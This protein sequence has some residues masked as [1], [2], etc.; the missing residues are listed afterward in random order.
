MVVAEASLSFLGLGVPVDRPSWGTTI[1]NGR[2]YLATA[3]WIATMPG[4]ALAILVVSIG[5]LGDELR[6]TLDPNLDA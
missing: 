3:W 5:F 6:D 1:A 2:D 4:I